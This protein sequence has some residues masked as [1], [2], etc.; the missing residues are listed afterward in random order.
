[1]SRSSNNN[2]LIT[3]NHYDQVV[4]LLLKVVTDTCCDRPREIW[5]SP[6]LLLLSVFRLSPSRSVPCSREVNHVTVCTSEKGNANW[7]MNEHT[8]LDVP[9]NFN[10]ISTLYVNF[11][12]AGVSLLLISNNGCQETSAGRVRACNGPRDHTGRNRRSV[13]NIA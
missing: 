6:V 4:V 8:T 1:M 7:T 11:F 3:N 12:S 2:V 9:T 5:A 10:C 13:L